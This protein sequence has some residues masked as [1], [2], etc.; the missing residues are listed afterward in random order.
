MTHFDVYQDAAWEWRF[1]LRAGNGEIIAQGEGYKELDSCLHTVRM[2]KLEVA[3]AKVVVNV[4]QEP[5]NHS[6]DA[7]D[8]K[9]TATVS[10]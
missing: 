5:A 7:L 10:L 2:M 8:V 3:E 6:T 9:Y 1:R 4:F